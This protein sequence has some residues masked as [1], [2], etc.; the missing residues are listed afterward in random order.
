MRVGDR[1][2]EYLELQKVSRKDFAEAIGV[3]YNSLS[4]M[5]T[6]GRSMQTDTIEKVLQYFP[7]LNARWLITGEGSP[8][9]KI[10]DAVSVANE[11]LASTVIKAHLEEIVIR[12]LNKK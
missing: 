6:E 10:V 8:E 3:N 1:L 11:L 2:K 4:R 12:Q 7:N 9:L 5:L